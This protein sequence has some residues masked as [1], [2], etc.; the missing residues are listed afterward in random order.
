[1]GDV[2][3]QG[4][5]PA[6][7]RQWL[8]RLCRRTD[9]VLWQSYRFSLGAAAGGAAAEWPRVVFPPKGRERRVGEQEARFAFVTALLTGDG[10]GDWAFAAECPTRLSYRFAHRGAG[11]KSQRALTDLALYRRDAASVGDRCDAATLSIEFKSGGRSGK[12][13]KDDS[14]V[15][16]MAKI[17]A[18]RP[19]ALWFHTVRDANSANL[20]GLLNALKASLKT[21]GNPVRLAD[22]V[23]LGKTA[24]PVPKAITFHICVLNPD[25][26]LSLHRTLD[27]RPKRVPGDFFEL[28]VQTLRSSLEIVDA[29]GWSVYQ[30]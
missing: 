5:S 15:K 16:D 7:D 29:R 9:D 13:E 4:F 10:A 1:M 2:P 11:E 12:S 24:T 23:A 21:M 28:D 27:Y 26:M 18:E 6:T 19:D 3:R 22:Y 25:L 20:Q 30:G 14:I 8:E 17:V